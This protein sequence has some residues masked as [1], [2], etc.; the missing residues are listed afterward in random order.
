MSQISLS[1]AFGAAIWLLGE[2]LGGFSIAPDL[3]HTGTG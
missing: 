2:A 1:A 3:Q